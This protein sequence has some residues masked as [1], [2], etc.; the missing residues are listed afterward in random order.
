MPFGRVILVLVGLALIAV[1]ALIAAA[2]SA[3]G[4]GLVVIGLVAV[5]LG[6]SNWH[7]FEAQFRALRFRITNA[8]PSPSVPPVE[9][10]RP[11]LRILGIRSTGGGVGHVDFAV[12]VA[13][14]GTRQCRATVRADVEGTGVECRP[15]SL[16]LI[17]N[18]PPET[19]RVLVPRPG[20]GDLLAP[21]IPNHTMLYNRTLTVVVSDGERDVRDT[22]HETVFDPTTDR[23]RSEVQMREWRFGRG[24]Q[25]T[26]DEIADQQS[27]LLRRHDERVER[28][29]KE[30]TPHVFPAPRDPWGMADKRS[31]RSFLPVTNGGS[32]VALNVRA[33]LEW[34]P[35][36]GVFVETV[37]TSLGPGESRDLTI[38]GQPPEDW[39][40]QVRGLLH[41]GDTPGPTWET[42]FRIYRDGNRYLVEVQET[43][44]LKAADGTVVA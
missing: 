39:G 21:A 13:N 6:V 20:L 27:A 15:S 12:E 29:S 36:S 33:R 35:P 41:Y 42:R 7:E 8:P 2:G 34:G 44:M 1:G 26:Q 16:D 43:R 10:Q 31:W 38:P 14:Y 23:A 40:Q 32:G 25:T 28:R 19:V 3:I 5:V 9:A 17:P 37:P 30:H 18:R 22:W 11:D 4:L 24:E